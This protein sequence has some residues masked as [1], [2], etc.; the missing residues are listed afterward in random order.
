MVFVTLVVTMIS[1]L[2]DIWTGV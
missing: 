1:C 2:T